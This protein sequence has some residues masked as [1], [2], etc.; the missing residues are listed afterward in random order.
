V[1]D[2]L[3]VPAFAFVDESGDPS[4][5]TGSRFLLLAAIM[6]TQPR[7]VALDVRRARRALGQRS[8]SGEFKAAL[9]APRITERFL[10]VLAEEEISGTVHE[11]R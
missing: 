2:L 7:A 8:P 1:S 11:T 5:M 4:R 3:R 10:K 9:T 6:T